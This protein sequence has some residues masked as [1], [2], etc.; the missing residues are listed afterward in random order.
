MMISQLH[1]ISREHEKATIFALIMFTD[2]HPHVIKVLDDPHYY[3]ALDDLSGADIAVFH[4]KLFKGCYKMPV[5]PPGT[6][7]YMVPVWEEPVQNKRLLPLFDMKDSSQ[8]PCLVTFL[9]D[10][11]VIYH[12]KSKIDDESEQKVFNSTREILTRLAKAAKN[13]DSRLE[14]IRMAKF[15]MNKL[16]FQ[17]DIIAFIKKLGQFRG[18]IGL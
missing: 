5:P 7:C 8:L 17:N 2:S 6:L 11:G 9:F 12:S 14:A 10:D 16:N 3:K 18:A 1:K 4:T 15:E 13:S